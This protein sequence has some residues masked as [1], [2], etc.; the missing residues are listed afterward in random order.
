[1]IVKEILQLV[2]IQCL[3]HEFCYL[4]FLSVHLGDHVLSLSGVRDFS[5]NEFDAFTFPV[6]VSVKLD[7]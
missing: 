1:M 4:N 6:E 3:G 2:I 7:A 5:F